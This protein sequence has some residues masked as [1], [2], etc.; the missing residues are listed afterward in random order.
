MGWFYMV[1]GH[2]YIKR[3]RFNIKTGWFYIKWGRFYIEK[4]RFYIRIIRFLLEINAFS[5]ALS[6][7][8]SPGSIPYIFNVLPFKTHHAPCPP[9]A[10]NIWK[11]LFAA[12]IFVSDK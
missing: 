7:A 6:F 11:L 10:F 8:N 9:I 1:E 5:A 4:N 2:F 12:F 3:P